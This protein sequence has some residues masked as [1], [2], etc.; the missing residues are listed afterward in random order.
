M[1]LLICIKSCQRDLERGDHNVIRSTWGKD[2]K[3]LG[4]DVKFFVGSNCSKY[5]SDEVHLK[6][7]DSYDALPYKTREICK[8]ASGKLIDYIFLCDTDTFV[9]PKLLLESGFETADFAGRFNGNISKP[10]RYEAVDRNGVAEVHERCYP[11]ASGGLGYFLSKKAFTEIAFEHPT[12]WAEDLWV[13]DVL[14]KLAATGEVSILDISERNYSFHFPQATYKS[15]YDP[16]FGWM[17]HMY[18]RHK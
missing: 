14:G 18:T 4:I 13:G 9:I 6:C 1:K 7:D 3:T 2:A 12:S 5:E 16:K 10:F 15:Q 11:W 17:E 8:W